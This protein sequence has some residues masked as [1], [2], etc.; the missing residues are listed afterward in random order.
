MTKFLSIGLLLLSIVF[1]SCSSDDNNSES[2]ISATIN[3]KEWKPTKINSVTLVKVPGYQQLFNINLQDNSIMLSLA[4]TSEL[5]NNDGMPVKQYN[6]F[7]DPEDGQISDALF[8]NTYLYSNGNTLTEHFPKSGKITVTSIDIA[9][10]TISGTFSF[11]SEKETSEDLKI[12]D[13]NPSSTP[14]VFEVTNGV[15]TNLSYTVT[16]SPAP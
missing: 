15:F 13:T 7:E 9:K 12:K 2:A 4:F 1:V 5:T 10:K 8:V 11:R 3:G 6:F 16:T 14:N